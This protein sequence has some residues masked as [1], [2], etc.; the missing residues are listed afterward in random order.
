VHKPSSKGTNKQEVLHFSF[1]LAIAIPKSS[2]Q[3][4]FHSITKAVYSRLF[5][6]NQ[7]GICFSH[8]AS[9]PSFQSISSQT[10]TYPSSA[11][12]CSQLAPIHFTLVATNSKLSE[13]IFLCWKLLSGA[14]II[15]IIREMNLLIKSY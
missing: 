14:R 13:N 15:Q 5:F 1:L 3:M 4:S 7:P 10:T 6:R 12:L 11:L 9:Q 2:I 8:P